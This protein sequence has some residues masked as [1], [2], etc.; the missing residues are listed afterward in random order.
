MKV[1]NY[2][3]WWKDQKKQGKENSIY[4]DDADETTDGSECESADP[5]STDDGD[6][7]ADINS[8]CQHLETLKDEAMHEHDLETDEMTKLTTT[9]QRG[10]DEEGRSADVGEERQAERRQ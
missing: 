9:E 1:L 4:D 5:P 2:S 7:D 6:H 3:N 10:L 8:R